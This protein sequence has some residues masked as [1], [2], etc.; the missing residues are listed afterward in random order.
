MQQLLLWM[1][2]ELPMPWP[3]KSFVVQWRVNNQE[4]HPNKQ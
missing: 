4:M 1:V 2:M 3:E